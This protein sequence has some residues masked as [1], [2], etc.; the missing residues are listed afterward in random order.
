LARVARWYILKPKIPFWQILE[1][2]EME[3]VGIF[4]TIW[5]ILR[6]TGKVYGHLVQ[7]WGILV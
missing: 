4:M 6:P 5:Y 3:D 7:F 2:L 1:G